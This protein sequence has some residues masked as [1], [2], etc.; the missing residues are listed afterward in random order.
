VAAARP[1][2]SPA[3]AGKEYRF[4]T[5]RIGLLLDDMRSRSTD[6]GPAD[7]VPGVELPTLAH[8]ERRRDHQDLNFEV[9]VD[10]IDGTP[11]R[12]VGPKPSSAYVSPAR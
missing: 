12:R 3:H 8:A 9:A 11:H 4:D 2:G 5:F 1:D 10:D 7:R 6:P